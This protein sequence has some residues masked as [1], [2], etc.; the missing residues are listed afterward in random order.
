MTEQTII[1]MKWGDR[2]GA[3]YVNRLWSMIRRH[4]VRPTWLVCFTDDAAG[5][6][7]EVETR[8]LPPLDIPEPYCWRGW[9]KIT[10]WDRTLPGIE[11]EALFL[12][13]D[14]VIT[15]PLDD[16]FDYAPGKFCIIRNFTGDGRRGIGNTSAYRFTVGSAPHLLDRLLREPMAVSDLHR[17]SQTFV[18]RESGLDMVFWPDGWCRSLK[19]ELIPKWPMN[20]IRPP[21]LPADARIITFTGKPDIDE[22]IEGR[23]PA[24]WHKKIYKHVRPTRWLAEHWG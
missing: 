18:S 17:N 24:P 6:D 12:D 7:P 1:C 14:L 11:G 9:R 22:V 3:D 8:P 2:Y 21:A 13:L 20:F 5:I 19:H 10:L 23:W 15:G 16:F 4:T